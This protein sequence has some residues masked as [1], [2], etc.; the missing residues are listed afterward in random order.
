MKSPVPSEKNKSADQSFA[1]AV[2]HHQAGRFAEA[3]KL[4]NAVLNLAP[5]HGDALRMLG[6]LYLQMKKPGDA[7][8]TLQAA[9]KVSPDNPE[10]LTN[11]GSLLLWQGKV[12]EAIP[13]YT[14]ALGLRPKDVGILMQLGR[15]MRERGGFDD[16]LGF[17]NR[18]LQIDPKQVDAYLG[19]A[20]CWWSTGKLDAAIHCYEIALTHKPGSAF[21]LA[22]LASALWGAGRR[23]EG[24]ARAEEALK[25][26]PNYTGA[27]VNR[28]IMAYEEVK[29]DEAMDYYER[30]LASSP[31]DREAR[32]RKSLVLLAR[33]DYG[34]GWKL[35]DTALGTRDPRRGP[36]FFQSK[37]WDGTK[38]PGKHLLIWCEQGLGDSLQ[39]IR[40]AKL[41]KERVGRVSVLC[42]KPLLRLFKS[43]P[44]IDAAFETAHEKDFDLHTLTMSLPHIFGTTLETVPAHM[45]YLAVDAKLQEKW[46]AKFKDVDGFKIGLVWAGSARE[47]QNNSGLV[48]QRRSIGLEKL[49]PLLDSPGARFYT[50]QKGEPAGQIKALGLE[51]RLIDLMSE[52]EDFADTAAIVN[53]LDLVISVDT[54]VAHLAGGLGKPV[55]I[56]SRYDACWRWLNNR[57]ETPW[58]PMGRIFGQPSPGD[59]DSVLKDLGREL[60]G[61]LHGR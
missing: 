38:A 5:Q 56:L 41:C 6:V 52:T 13:L 15:M 60:E 28:G 18:A 44:Y 19:A 42:P 22:N 34:E 43:S 49:K 10:I 39:F 37:P 26:E 57:R 11:L 32:W 55:W 16:A 58:Y 61:L 51:N 31:E 23:D 59:W 25:V 2:A 36:N 12:A 14:R 29:F 8:P 46:D 53:N 35:F 3:E 47:G 20:S 40:Y 1:E 54:S 9:L 45:P 50:L 33:G 48:D 4:Y 30:A 17:Y 21:I 7:L 24:K 27:L